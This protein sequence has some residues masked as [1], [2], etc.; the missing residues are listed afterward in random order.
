MYQKLCF[1]ATY[2]ENSNKSY[3]LLFQLAYSQG[4]AQLALVTGTSQ[5]SQLLHCSSEVGLVVYFKSCVHPRAHKV[6]R[7]KM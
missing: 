5:G 1:G 7:P 4:T 3:S 2:Y 6:S